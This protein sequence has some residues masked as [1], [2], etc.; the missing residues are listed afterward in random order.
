M[1]S[2]AFLANAGITIAEIKNILRNLDALDAVVKQVQDGR[3]PAGIPVDR[4]VF[5][6]GILVSDRLRH[7]TVTPIEAADLRPIVFLDVPPQIVVEPEAD[8]R[9]G[10]GASALRR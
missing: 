9:L 6:S 5:Q 2:T 7:P 1:E 3:R 4:V 10:L 8:G